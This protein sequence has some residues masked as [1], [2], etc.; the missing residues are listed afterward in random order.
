MP[1]PL[2]FI[3]PCLPTKAPHPPTG[4]LWAVS[5]VCWRSFGTFSRTSPARVCRLPS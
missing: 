1:L 3:A 5:K 4:A 2:G